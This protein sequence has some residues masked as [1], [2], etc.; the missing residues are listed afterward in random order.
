MDS[1]SDFE[2][3]P[4]SQI[5]FCGFNNSQSADYGGDVIDSDNEFEKVNVIS[6][7]NLEYERSNC[8]TRRIL[9]DNIEIEDISSDD[10]FF[11]S[12]WK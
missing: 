12:F 11:R 8:E 9:Y 3:F 7:E 4:S 1:D 10:D 5:S 6:L 2:C